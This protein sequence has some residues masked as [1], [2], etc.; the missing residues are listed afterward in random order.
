MVREGKRLLFRAR[1][2]CPCRCS[3]T[4]SPN[5][6]LLLIPQV[7][8]EYGA[9]V[10]LF[11]QEKPEE[12]W[13]IPVLSALWPPLVAHGLTW[14]RVRTSAARGQRLTAW[15]MKLPIGLMRQSS[16][17]DD[18]FNCDQSFGSSSRCLAKYLECFWCRRFGETYCLHLPGLK[19][20]LA[21]LNGPV[22]KNTDG[23]TFQYLAYVGLQGWPR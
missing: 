13:E 10:E 7:V 9:P 21:S 18:E 15:A 3:E 23:F 8:H 12:I 1:C 16:S 14:A 4:M 6:G 2:W 11:W 17:L 22:L 5:C 19:W 20:H